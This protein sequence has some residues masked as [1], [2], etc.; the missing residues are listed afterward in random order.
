MERD[1]AV[2]RRQE[3]MSVCS[4]GVQFLYN[5]LPYDGVSCDDNDF[6]VNGM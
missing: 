2:G 6:D 1:I 5:P 3:G 4:Y